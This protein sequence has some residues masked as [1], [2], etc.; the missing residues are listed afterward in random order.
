MEKGQVSGGVLEVGEMV[1]EAPVSGAL[2]PGTKA[3]DFS[4]KS[5]PKKTIKLSQL[6]GR[7][8]VLI[9]YPAD[10]SPVCTDELVVFNEMLPEFAKYNAQLLGISVDGVWSHAAFA[11]ERNLKFP[12][13]ADYEP[14]GAVARSYGVYRDKDGHN[15]RALF[16]IDGEGIIYWNY[17]SPVGVNPGAEGALKALEELS[18]RQNK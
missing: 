18:R 10:F 5:E 12:L 7:P 16:V 6:R 3:P 8:V 9:F 2:K 15:E 4:L 1:T 14:K 13:L 11:R 17:V